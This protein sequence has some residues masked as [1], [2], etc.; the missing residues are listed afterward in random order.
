MLG[1]RAEG[2]VSSAQQ[3]RTH[4]DAHGRP[5]ARPYGATDL[6]ADVHAAADLFRV[7]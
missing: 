7:V 2:P 1:E 5:S 4:E 6:L 3:G